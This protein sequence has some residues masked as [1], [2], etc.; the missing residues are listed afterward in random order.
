[1]LR[2]PPALACMMLVFSVDRSK[3]RNG[4]EPL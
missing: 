3:A 4:L 2:P 1:M